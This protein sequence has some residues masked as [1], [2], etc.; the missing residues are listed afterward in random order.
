MGNIVF[1][2]LSKIALHTKFLLTMVDLS[3]THYDLA[4]DN[5]Q[6]LL[7]GKCLWDMKTS[8]ILTTQKDDKQWEIMHQ[9][10]VIYTRWEKLSNSL[11]ITRVFPGEVT[12]W[13][14]NPERI[15]KKKMVGLGQIQ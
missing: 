12:I 15:N 7:K 10:H 11:E 14:W 4:L 5:E 8:Y 9:E 3:V 2:T 6:I 1:Q 13:Q